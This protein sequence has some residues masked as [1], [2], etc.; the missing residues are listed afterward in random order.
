MGELQSALRM[1]ASMNRL[2]TKTLVSNL[3]PCTRQHSGR[4]NA[5]A[6]PAQLKIMLLLMLLLP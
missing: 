3:V 4:V 1:S 2:S 6:A 5:P